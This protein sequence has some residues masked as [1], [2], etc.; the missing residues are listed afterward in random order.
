MNDYT[1]DLD[2]LELDTDV[3]ELPEVRLPPRAGPR[4][5]R[6]RGGEPGATGES[7]KGDTGADGLPGTKGDKGDKG[8]KGNKGD[9]GEK[10]ERGD[11][12]E[13]G[14]FTV[15][16][17]GRDGRNGKDADPTYTE[18]L[19]RDAVARIPKPKDGR[20]V[21]GDRGIQGANGWTPIPLIEEAGRRLA[22]LK[23]ADWFGG[24]GEKPPI[25]YITDEGISPD[26]KKAI[27]IRGP[28]GPAG[29]DGASGSGSRGRDGKSAYQVAVDNGFVGT[30]A[31]W[32]ES[33][34]GSGSGSGSASNS[35]EAIADGTVNGHRAVRVTG[36]DK[37]ALVDSTNAA[38]AGTVI[39]IST[40]AASDGQTV[41]VQVIGEIDEPTFNFTPGPVYF[42]D[43]GRLTQTVPT[44]GFIQQVAVALSATV[45]VVQ[46]GPPIVL[47]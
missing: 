28:K 20:T 26:K 9:R 45:V 18:K 23:I 5:V 22:Y 14:L 41:T 30:E 6:G 12:G 13:R 11:R 16:E 27:N 1:T 7:V 40:T 15:G 36:S 47:N 46:I 44:S 39:G 19:V 17:K 29:E 35:I 2:T 4:G 3:I 8:D 33:L 32:L 38:Q 43:V 31:E 21:I 24:E 34:Q 10:G 42:D 25:G 37:V